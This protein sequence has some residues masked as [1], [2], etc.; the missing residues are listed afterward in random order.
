VSTPIQDHPGFDQI[1]RLLSGGMPSRATAELLTSIGFNN[2]ERAARGLQTLAL[3]PSFPRDDTKFLL[4]FLESIG[5]TF[6]PEQALTNLERIL[7]SRENP[8]ALLNTLRRSGERRAVVLT[9]AGGSQFLSDTL[10]RHPEFLDWILRPSTLRGERTKQKMFSELWRWVRAAEDEPNGPANA[11][12]KFRQ[13]EYLR[14]GVRDLLRWASMAETTQALSNLADITLEAALRISQGELHTLYGKPRWRAP[15]GGR[16]ACEFAVIGMGKLGGQ[17]LNFSSDIDLLFIYSSDEGGTTGVRDPY[18][19]KRKGQISNH[20]FS[21]RLAQRVIQ[22]MAENT[23]EGH[24]FRVDMRLRPEGA[25]GALSYSLRSCEVYYESWGETWE[26]QAMI[27]A[28][29]CAGSEQLG[30]AFHQ[31]IRPFIYRQTMDV[32]ALDEIARIKDRINSKLAESGREHLNIKL[33]EGGIREIEFIIQSF[34]LIYGGKES[35]LREA[36]SLHALSVIKQLGLLPID[37]C[38]GL[39]MA[40]IFLRDIEHRVQIIHGLQ[41]HEL[42]ADAH[43]L[44]VLARKMGFRV[45]GHES[46][47]NAFEEELRKHQDHVGKVF[48]NLFRREDSQQKTE[49]K[50]PTPAAPASAETLEDSLSPSDLAPYNFADPDSA[51]GR[52]RLLRN[53]EPFQ[54]ISARAKRSFDELL[55]RIL[56]LTL[57]LPDPDKAVANLCRFV[58]KGGGREA[59]FT[60]L[61]E[62]DRMF[63]A[64]LKLFG[65]SDYLSDI[66]IQQP[67]VFDT[68]IQA[69][70]LT[71]SKNRESLHSDIHLATQN[72]SS[73]AKRFGALASAKRG[74][75]F[76]IG[77][78]SILGESDIIE[79]LTDL[80]NLADVVV[81][82][83]LSIA[84]E[85]MRALHDK[86]GADKETTGFAIIGLGKLGSCEMNFGSD[87]DLIF[88]YSGASGTTSENPSNKG[89]EKKTSRGTLSPHDYYLRIAT[90]LRD[91]LTAPEAGDRAYEIDLRL[92]PEGQKGGLIVPIEQFKTYFDG[93]AESWEKQALCRARHI[94]GSKDIGEQ[95]MALSTKFVYES[96]LPEDF[97]G[98]VDHMR[99]RMERE[100]A[101]ESEGNVDIKLGMGGIADIDFIVQFLQITQGQDNPSLRRPDSFG[102]IQAFYEAGLLSETEKNTLSES[103]QFLRLVENRLRIANAQSLHTLPKS[104]EEMEILA[105]RI[106]YEDDE[107][108]SSRAKLLSD[109]EKHTHQVREIYRKIMS[110]VDEKRPLK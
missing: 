110:G 98:E 107:D 108:G 7:E 15:D 99:H 26:R 58:E 89:Q 10:L 60:L 109:Y 34:Q 1:E 87:L 38:E 85:E 51:S 24:I 66:L 50:K 62:S 71:E 101:R 21:V 80:T 96:P 43:G 88:A 81:K 93:R 75:E 33:G 73:M 83:G 17:E 90:T 6:E 103:Y 14:I 9:L 3:H 28:R 91:G 39:A 92:R 72:I 53:G 57:A 105:R 67:A 76:I 63:E 35:L 59:V 42:P 12:R 100:L 78:R 27:K 41:T 31:M 45:D 48:E 106:G 64:L 74:E 46:E 95:F 8:D 37:D 56:Y 49:P 70:V 84:E 40:Y 69:G 23:E 94:A 44:T 30:Q 2:Q 18:T 11:M 13:R 22:L 29:L 79:T 104:P 61:G 65:S 55:P 47:K 77:M 5:E 16:L 20:D 54:H 102:A 25:Q 52:L 97:A 19:G 4:Q 68:I 32:S 86:P 36:N 82:I